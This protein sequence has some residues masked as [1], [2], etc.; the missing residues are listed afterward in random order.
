MNEIIHLNQP[1]NLKITLNSGQVF[2]WKI[3]KDGWNGFIDNHL[4]VIHQ[5]NSILTIN[6]SP[7]IASEIKHLV[8]NFLRLDDNIVEIY[9]SLE[10]YPRM[11]SL[12]SKFHGLR[13]IRQ[14]PWECL[15]SFICSTNMNIVRN[16][17][18]Q[19]ALAKNFGHQT[20]LMNIK[21]N[22]F[23]SPEAIYDAGISKLQQIGLGY[24]AKYVWEASKM[25]RNG[26]LPL[27]SLK[28]TTYE[29]ARR[30]LLSVPGV[31][32]KVADCVLLFSLD[33]IESFPIDRWISKELG[34]QKTHLS[35]KHYDFLASNARKKYGGIAGYAQQFLFLSQRSL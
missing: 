24:R 22:T 9:K 15:I 25:V 6:F 8:S 35:D 21:R 3:Y 32:N 11:N 5:K 26:I 28:N 17:G 29:N 31:G 33:K 13:L 27:E 18:I 34:N 20:E 23:P 2:R 1:I 10:K 14:N 7:S 12:L 4:I 16:T 30:E 19:E